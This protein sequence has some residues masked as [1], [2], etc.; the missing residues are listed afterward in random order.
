MAKSDSPK[1]QEAKSQRLMEGIKNPDVSRDRS[2]QFLDDPN[3]GTRD[4]TDGRAR[5][6]WKTRYP[7]KAK[8]EILLESIY[9]SIIFFISFFLIF[10]IWKGWFS[11]LILVSAEDI[12]ILKKYGYYALS[13]MLGGITFS[14]KYLYRVVARGYWHQ[15]RRIWRLMSPFQA[16]TLSFI[17]GAMIDA[18]FIPAQRPTSGAATISIGFL[19][20]YF[21][22]EAIGKMYEI[23][24][25]IFGRT[26]SPK[27]GDG[28]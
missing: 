10:T 13:G 1:R 24:K 17:M 23:A 6:D 9:L 21:A 2:N 22:D 11:S 20:G 8:C 28:K 15:D 7:R 19:V 12:L 25:V 4:P 5:Y 3:A 18:S 26:A 16:M 27:T 14:I